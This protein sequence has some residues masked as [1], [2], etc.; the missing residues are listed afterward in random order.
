MFEGV[1]NTLLDRSSQLRRSIKKAIVKK[2]AILSPLLSGNCKHT[3]ICKRRLNKNSMVLSKNL[4][5]N[6]MHRLKVRPYLG[7]STGRLP[8]NNEEK[9]I[10]Q[11]YWSLKVFLEESGANVKKRW[12]ILI[13]FCSINLSKSQSGKE[14]STTHLSISRICAVAN[15]SKS[16]VAGRTVLNVSKI[17]YC[18]INT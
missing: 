18:K 2:F 8:S 12:Q 16:M 6:L 10:L 9:R 7:L 4:K 11:T 17:C 1:L 5:W 15:Y 14:W 13:L 3:N